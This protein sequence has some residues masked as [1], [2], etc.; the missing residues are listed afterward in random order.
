MGSKTLNFMIK[1]KTTKKT[2]KILTKKT[3]AKL[4]SRKKEISNG[5]W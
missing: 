5:R 4:V 3:K 1:K 2:K